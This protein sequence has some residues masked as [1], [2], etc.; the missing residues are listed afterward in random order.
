MRPATEPDPIGLAGGLNAY[1]YS[2]GE[3]VNRSA[4]FGLCPK[5]VGGDGKS[6]SVDD[7]PQDVQDAWA[8]THSTNTSTNNTDIKGIGANLMRAVVLTSMHHR[9]SLG[10]SAGK[11]AGHSV[12]G[13]HSDG[14]GVDINKVYGIRFGAMTDEAAMAVGNAIAV[15]IANRLSNGFKMV[16]SRGMAAR[17]HRPMTIE[18]HA[19]IV[20]KHRTH[21]HVTANPPE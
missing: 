21:V 9:V 1:G 19:E 17:T 6:Q 15:G 4:P 20:R 8:S 14:F 10:I 18:Q 3:P 7:C 11:E 5:D 13:L 12:E 16:Y 2:S